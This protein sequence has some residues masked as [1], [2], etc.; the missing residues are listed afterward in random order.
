MWLNIVGRYDFF[1]IDGLHL[2]GMEGA[3]LGCEFVR[4]VDEGTS[5]VN[6]LNQMRSRNIQRK[7]KGVQINNNKIVTNYF[8]K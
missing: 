2:P 3:V 6:Y 7:L 1:M 8:R 4:V 5:T